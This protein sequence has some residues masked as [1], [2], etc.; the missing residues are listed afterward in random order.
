[1]NE[2]TQPVV[3]EQLEPALRSQND[4]INTAIHLTGLAE[5]LLD[6]LAN[7]ASGE[8]IKGAANIAWGYNALAE[9]ANKLA[10]DISDYAD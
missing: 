5:V 6:A 8:E 4:L 3:D 1:M 10:D 9:L 2:T 7:A